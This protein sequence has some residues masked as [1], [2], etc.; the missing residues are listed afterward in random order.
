MRQ[1]IC[2]DDCLSIFDMIDLELKRIMETKPNWDNKKS[3][4]R[5]KFNRSV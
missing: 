4:V 3:V 1:E 2:L 5:H